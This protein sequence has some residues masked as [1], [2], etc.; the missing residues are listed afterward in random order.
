MVRVTAVHDDVGFL[1]GGGDG[2]EAVVVAVDDLDVRVGRTECWWLAAEK[3]DDGPVWVCGCEGVED[4]A[5]DVA[6]A[7]GAAC[8]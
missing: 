6:C 7:A 2:V 4:G 3:C 8:G 1:G 5:T